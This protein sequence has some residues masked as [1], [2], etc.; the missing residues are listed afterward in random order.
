MHGETTFERRN[1][2]R[3]CIPTL[4]C[5]TRCQQAL[6]LALYEFSTMKVFRPIMSR[7]QVPRACLSVLVSGKGMD[8]D[9]MVAC[10]GTC[11]NIMLDSKARALCQSYEP[12][13]VLWDMCEMTHSEFADS[14]H[15]RAI[16][17]ATVR[18]IVDST[19]A[20][21]IKAAQKMRCQMMPS[22][23]AMQEA[24]YKQ[25]PEKAN[26]G[27]G[28]PITQDQ[29]M[30]IVAACEARELMRI[31]T[32]VKPR[33]L[34]TARQH[35]TTGRGNYPAGT[36]ANATLKT[37]HE[38]KLRVLRAKSLAESKAALLG[39]DGQPLPGGFG[40]DDE[41]ELD[42]EELLAQEALDALLGKHKKKETGD[43]D[44]DGGYEGETAEERA[45]RKQKEADDAK[46]GDI[47]TPQE[48]LDRRAAV[49]MQE[50][51]KL[52]KMRRIAREKAL[53]KKG[54]TDWRVGGIAEKNIDASRRLILGRVVKDE[55]DIS[56][57]EDDS[58]V[59]AGELSGAQLDRR[60]EN[61]FD[62]YGNIVRE[63]RKLRMLAT[64][65]GSMG[66]AP[67]MVS[68]ADIE[69]ETLELA[70]SDRTG[71]AAMIRDIRAEEA[72]ILAEEM[73]GQA[74]KHDEFVNT[75]GKHS[76]YTENITTVSK[77][78]E[79]IYG[80]W[81]GGSETDTWTGG[82]DTPNGHGLVKATLEY[83]RAEDVR[84]ELRVYSTEIT[85]VGGGI[86]AGNG[87]D[88][89][90]K[91]RQ[92]RK[93][94]EKEAARREMRDPTA[95]IRSNFQLRTHHARARVL[96]VNDG[97]MAFLPQVDAGSSAIFAQK[98]ADMEKRALDERMQIREEL[99][100]VR[101][102]AEARDQAETSAGAVGI[103]LQGRSLADGDA[104]RLEK[105]ALESIA[106]SMV[107]GAN[108]RPKKHND[109]DPWEHLTDR[110]GGVQRTSSMGR[111]GLGEFGLDFK[112]G[113]G[114]SS[115]SGLD[116]GSGEL[117][118]LWGNNANRNGGGAG[119]SDNAPAPSPASRP[120]ANTK[121]GVTYNTS[122]SLGAPI[123][124]TL[125]G[126][127]GGGGGGGGWTPG[128]PS[129]ASTIR[130][131]R[132][133]PMN[134]RASFGEIPSGVWKDIEN[135]KSV[136]ARVSGAAAP[137]KANTVQLPMGQQTA[138]RRRGGP[139]HRFVKRRGKSGA[140]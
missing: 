101:A 109:E 42:E 44:S 85:N 18:S 22:L 45:R 122:A 98:V 14:I 95:G 137:V 125:D 15:M 114:G 3:K 81:Q 65:V 49:K 119:R 17:L 36:M 123:D 52:R 134:R 127:G 10:A 69:Y 19:R 111:Q 46:Y 7:L 64:P 51:R 63:G 115:G 37:L 132:T 93:R 66:A 43:D 12:G 89:S 55:D 71:H 30:I 139:K 32:H 128:P 35:V 131:P 25:I 48:E 94:R 33:E 72:R 90:R 97:D 24:R 129:A 23:L 112:N 27:K 83:N 102:T 84:R 8:N 58:D 4:H 133:V 86:G 99:G 2:L 87:G 73:V 105:G 107:W 16:L 96:D 41:E 13:T 29:K 140:V 138:R 68:W 75:F 135:S 50:K 5:F 104:L 57:D 54:P 34:Q 106:E 60:V 113:S 9:A 120:I 118:S 1:R 21:A 136:S 67:N 31:I 126:Q 116:R 20:E 110:H 124:T 130:M 74:S 39:P 88:T 79:S 53:A 26:A 70:N 40:R 78:A 100:R 80:R 28:G 108:G 76:T 6:L 38:R 92:R 47:A 82:F 62:Q 59:E 103:T 77:K 61:S 91:A 56:S 11:Y 117:P 121:Y